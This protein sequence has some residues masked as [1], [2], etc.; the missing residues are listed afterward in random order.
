[1]FVT[2]CMVL[3]IAAVVEPVGRKANWSLRSEWVIE[4]SKKWRTMNRSNK[5]DNNGVT[6]T[7]RRSEKQFGLPVLGRGVTSALFQCIQVVNQLREKIENMSK[8]WNNLK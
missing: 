2:V 4:G 1:M 7:G 8:N 5:R 3:T 6:D